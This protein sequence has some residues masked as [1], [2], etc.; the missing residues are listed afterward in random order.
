MHKLAVVAGLLVFLRPLIAQPTVPSRGIRIETLSIS[1][2]TQVSMPDRQSVRDEVISRCCDHAE[3]QEIRE[4]IVYAFQERGYYKARVQQLEVTPLDLHT[5][6]PSVTVVVTVEDGYQYRLKSVQFSGAKAFAASQLRQQFAISD[7][8]IFNAEKIRKGLDN[9]RKLYAS[10]GY[11]NLTPV[12]N[13]ESDDEAAAITL[14][15]DLDEG[16]QFHLGGLVLDGEELHPGDGA[17]LLAAWKPMEGGVYDGTRVE[18]WWR[19]AATLLPPGS[20]MEQMLGLRQDAT[21]SI[22][23]GYLRFPDSK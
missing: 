1:G 14:Q 13:T 17:K 2:V 19:L 18:A 6:P 15:I 8:D 16:K 10:R 23:T 20:H 21:S 5:V 22:V 4:R 11:V 12:P 3:T 9:L 7:G